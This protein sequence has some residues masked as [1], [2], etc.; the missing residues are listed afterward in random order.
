MRAM[1]A[2]NKQRCVVIEVVKRLPSF[3]IKRQ[4]NLLPIVIG[5]GASVNGQ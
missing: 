2:W 4:R 3:R 5:P 1:G